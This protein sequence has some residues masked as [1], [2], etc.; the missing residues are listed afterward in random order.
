MRINTLWYFSQR[1]VALNI[2]LMA[3]VYSLTCL[4]GY[5]VFAYYES[6]NCDILR[7]PAVGNQNQVRTTC[8]HDTETKDRGIGS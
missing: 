6:I 3:I 7:T 8:V 2:P 4:C 1:A 5:A